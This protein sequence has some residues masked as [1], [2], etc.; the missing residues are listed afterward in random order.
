M[1][2]GT[3]IWG[4]ETPENDSVDFAPRLRIPT[5]MLNGR[6]DFSMPPDTAQRPLFERLGA[7]PGTSATSS[8]IAGTRCRSTTR[9][10]CCRG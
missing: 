1:L 10:S 7:P 2:Q 9:A 3:G 5:L 6:Y 8:S 4:D